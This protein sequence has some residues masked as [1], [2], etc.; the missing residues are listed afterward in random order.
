MYAY[1]S[2]EKWVSDWSPADYSYTGGKQVLLGLEAAMPSGADV[3][4]SATPLTTFPATFSGTLLP[5]DKSAV[6]ASLI[7]AGGL[8]LS[9]TLSCDRFVT[10][11][12]PHG[13]NLDVSNA[14]AIASLGNLLSASLIAAGLKS[15]VT[16]KKGWNA[17]VREALL[18]PDAPVF[19]SVSAD[20]TVLTLTLPPMPD[21]KPKVDESLNLYHPVGDARVGPHA[22]DGRGLHRQH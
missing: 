5:A 13:S 2:S 21:Y 19:A 6:S 1:A 16:V 10:P 7:R 4:I 8:T 17:V 12:Y 9:I 3:N 11:R 15:R 22:A 18:A 20:A 14:E